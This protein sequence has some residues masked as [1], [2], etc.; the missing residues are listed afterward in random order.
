MQGT[1]LLI[2]ILGSILVLLP[3]PAI[4]LA[5]YVGVI[6][7]YPEYLRLSIGTIDISAGRIVITMLLLR[8]MLSDRLRMKFVWSRFD[9]WVALSIAVYVVMYCITHP[10]G[11][12]LE[13]HGGMAIDTWFVYLAARF[14][15]TDRKSLVTVVKSIAFILVPLAL[16]GVIEATT[17]WQPF[18]HLRQYCPWRWE[19]P[20]Y[21][22]RWGMIRAWGPFSHPIMFGSCFV[23]FLPLIWWLRHQ[24]GYLG[25]L[26]KTLS[27]AVIVGA[28]S[29]LSS[30]PWGML[31][32][33]IF[34]LV[35]ER[36]HRRLKSVLI[37]LFVLCVLAEVGSNRPFHHVV[38]SYCNFGRGDWYQRARLIDVAIDH[39]DEWWLAGYGAEG[40]DWSRDLNSNVTDMNNE[41]LL[42]GVKYGMLGVIA[43]TAVLVGAYRGLAH[44]FKET[45]DKEL[46][47]LYWALGSTLTGVIVI[48]Q[49]V[50]FFGQST[51][52][53]YCVLGMVG[54]SFALT[55]PVRAEAGRVRIAS[56]DGSA[57]L[58]W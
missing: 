42:K 33:V 45:K 8:C 43:L 7:W 23:M 48:W 17:G 30:G 25:R 26:A 29:S 44:G 6:V 3:R 15:I 46:R 24:R 37:G 10:L 38:L 53:F 54:S 22:A 52:L 9:T 32:I 4:A 58:H 39:F 2:G 35:L 34:C 5:A 11:E 1:T 41:F 12:A 13:N 51:S 20:A 31:T 28:M 49:G 47:S 14:C 19:I 40:V 36:Y 55:R 57:V 27:A 21:S 18:V 16:L 50:S 56:T